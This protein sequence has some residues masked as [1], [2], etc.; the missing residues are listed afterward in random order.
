LAFPKRQWFEE[1][2]AINSDIDLHLYFDTINARRDFCF[3]ALAA[4]AARKGGETRLGKVQF[5]KSFPHFFK[6]ICTN[7]TELR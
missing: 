6:I 3:S 7:L 2:I 1:L 4:S 5:A